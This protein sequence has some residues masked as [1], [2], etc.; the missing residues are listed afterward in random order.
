MSSNELSGDHLVVLPF[1]H[2]YLSIRSVRSFSLQ[3]IHHQESSGP[4]SVVDPKLT[5]R[6][7]SSE[8]LSCP[9]DSFNPINGRRSFTYMGFHQFVLLA[10]VTRSILNLVVHLL[11]LPLNK[12]EYYMVQWVGG[13]V[14]MLSTWI[15]YLW[16]ASTEGVEGERLFLAWCYTNKPT[17][18]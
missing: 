7:L 10:W 14:L 13:T 1:G 3:K 2:W 9:G 12:L 16:S 15:W 18:I 17:L 4:P 6:S 8:S 11:C 5:N